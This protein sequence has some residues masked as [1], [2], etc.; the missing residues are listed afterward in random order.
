MP[1]SPPQRFG[2]VAELEDFL[3]LPSRELIDD[4]SAVDG[5]LMILGVAGQDGPHAGPAGKTAAPHKRVI[6]VARF[7]DAGRA[8]AARRL[9]HRDGG[10]RPARRAPSRRCR[11]VP[12]IVFAAG[13]KFGA[14]DN[15][16]L[17]WAMNTHV[18]ALVADTFRASRIV[19]FSTGNVY[20]SD[21][22][23]AAGASEATPPSPIGE[24]AQSCL[25]RERHV[26]STSPP[27]HG[28]P[29]R[30]VRLNY[31]NRHA[32]RRAAGHRLAR[33][34]PRA[35]GRLDGPRERDL[36]GRREHAGA[37][38]A[39]PLHDARHPDQLHGARDGLRALARHPL[40]RAAR[41]APHSSRCAEAGTALLSD[42]TQ[43]SRLLRLPRVPL[44]AMIEWVAGLGAQRRPEL[45]QAHQVRSARWSVL[46]DAPASG[47]RAA[48]ARRPPMRPA[49]LALSSAAGWN[50]T[51]DDWRS[52]SSAAMP[53]A[54][55]RR[56]AGSS[57]PAAA[58]PYGGGLGWISMVLVAPAHR[59]H[60]AGHAADG[61]CVAALQ[62]GGVRPVLDAT[63]AGA[64]VY[65]RIGFEPGFELGAVG[66]QG[67]SARRETHRSTRR[68]LRPRPADLRDADAIAALDAVVHR[69]RPRLA[70]ASVPV[71][72]PT[73]R[74][75]LSRAADGSSSSR[76]G[77]RATQVGP[78]VA[79]VETR[80]LALLRAALAAVSGRPSWTFPCAGR[81]C[82]EALERCGFRRQRPFVRMA[83][84]Q[85]QTLAVPPHLFVLAGPEFG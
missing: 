33:L 54:G 27:A 52:S 57:P 84:G 10:G 35:G 43:A 65:R 40:R 63:P 76:A 38:P 74:A 59:H 51:A 17:T 5:D 9:G 1:G 11:A 49:G 31:A 53:S 67:R 48:A 20:P 24:Y 22:A 32:L 42:T 7:S 85:A 30:I 61:R 12:N 82:A 58:L 36:A 39:A 6:G 64:P 79:P 71:A 81:P 62:R 14:K 2:S 66:G 60:G 56:P 69:P 4:L 28:T 72:R 23:R 15:Q 77:H 47:A 75:W 19:A 26:R 13:H 80:A 45:Q 55:A 25:G 68:A 73:T 83:L 78:L 8:P 16:P 41:R 3:A 18:A 34:A 37:A 50:Q 70:A 46:T 29:G 44:G 21:A